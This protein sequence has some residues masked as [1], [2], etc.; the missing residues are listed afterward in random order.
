MILESHNTESPS[1]GVSK[2]DLIAE[3][4]AMI[5]ATDNTSRQIADNLATMQETYSMS[6]RQI[7]AAVG[8]SQKWVGEM[9]RWRR[10]G[11]KD[12]T[13]FGPQAKEAREQSLLKAKAEGAAEA[14][15]P[16]AEPQRGDLKIT[17][18][19]D[20]SVNTDTANLLK[21][22][23]SPFE[24]S[25][26]IARA[27]DDANERAPAKPTVSG[28]TTQPKKGSQEWWLSEFDIAC[29]TYFPKMEQATLAQ[30]KAIAAAWQPECHLRAV[31]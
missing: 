16:P 26:I 25:L 20:V 8:K 5:V 10:E 19:R 7:A 31:S 1:T 24:R 13:P 28:S 21:H 2:S 27:A 29:K 30:A 6:Q 18:R 22:V 4:K 14:A 23:R 17:D 12:D 11:F 9:L 15:T 3:T